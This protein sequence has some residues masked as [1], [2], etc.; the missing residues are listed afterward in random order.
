[1]GISLRSR[2]LEIRVISGENISVTE[3]AYVVVRAESLNSCTTTTAKYDGT[4]LLAWNHKLLLHVPAH[5]TSITFEV[6]CNKFKASRPLG[7]ARIALSDFLSDNVS[8]NQLQMLSYGLRN[9]EGKQ[10]G[11]IHFAVRVAPPPEE[12]PN[13]AVEP[14]K[15]TVA[16]RGCG[17]RFVRI[18]NVGDN[19]VVGVPYSRNYP[20]II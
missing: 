7:V 10:N 8:E 16:R 2:T 15:G 17:D 14:V 9:W 11:V 20:N 19:V 3:A 4:N 1:M 6:Q 12:C 13:S 18:I 5:A